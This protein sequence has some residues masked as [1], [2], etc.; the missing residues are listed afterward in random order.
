MTTMW[1]CSLKNYVNSHLF[2][3]YINLRLQITFE[4]GHVNPSFSVVSPIVNLNTMLQGTAS[5]L[6]KRLF[7]NYRSDIFG[8]LESNI[9]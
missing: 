3:F 7:Q 2:I 9:N 6:V 5:P 8:D 4:G 1:F